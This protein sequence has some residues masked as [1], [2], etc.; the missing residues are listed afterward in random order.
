MHQTKKLLHSSHRVDVVAV[1]E[2]AVVANAIP[3]TMITNI[4][5]TVVAD[6]AVI[7]DIS[8][9]CKQNNYL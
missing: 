8:F 9:N 5:T 1:A 2:A 7:A 4:I 3:T 6:V